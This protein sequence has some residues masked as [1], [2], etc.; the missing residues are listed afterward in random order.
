MLFQFKHNI[1]KTITIDS[2]KIIPV[3]ETW[4]GQENDNRLSLINAILFYQ[5]ESFWVDSFPNIITPWIINIDK[6]EVNKIFEELSFKY[7]TD[8]DNYQGLDVIDVPLD[9]NKFLIDN[10]NVK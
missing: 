4:N 6:D 9:I 3:S 5:S 10:F 2:S 8:N 7:P 1:Y